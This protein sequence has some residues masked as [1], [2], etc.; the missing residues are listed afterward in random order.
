MHGS[1][2]IC[3]QC[4]WTPH[5]FACNFVPGSIRPSGGEHR[6][7]E[8]TE[9]GGNMR[10]SGNG[11]FRTPAR[12]TRIGGRRPASHVR[13]RHGCH[14]RRLCRSGA[15]LRPSRS[16]AVVEAGAAVAGAVVGVTVS[17]PQSASASARPSSAV[18]L[19]RA[20]PSSSGG[21]P[22]AIACSAIVRTIRIARPISAMTA[23]VVPVRS[24]RIT[25]T[26]F[27]DPGRSAG[28]FVCETLNLSSPAADDPVFRRRQR[29]ADKPRRAGSV[30]ARG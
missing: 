17:A 20:P 26:I 7:L 9:K 30:L 1:A 6:L 15:S 5:R 14:D 3:P 24:R 4:A 11:Q 10:T 8:C 28:V 16:A 2:H 21:M 23:C 22:S 29:H 18:R 19:R 12:H 27:Q 13:I 25:F